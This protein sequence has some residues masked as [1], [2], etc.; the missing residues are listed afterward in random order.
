[1]WDEEIGARLPYAFH[2]EFGFLTACPTNAPTSDQRHKELHHQFRLVDRELS[3]DDIKLIDGICRATLE[4]LA[5]AGLPKTARQ[6]TRAT[7]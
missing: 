5:N 6:V 2:H 3:D 1:M 7:L 4:D